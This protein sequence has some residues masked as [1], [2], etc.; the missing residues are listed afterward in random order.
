M[1]NF[2]SRRCNDEAGY[3][4]KRWFGSKP[5]IQLPPDEPFAPLIEDVAPWVNGHKVFVMDE[6]GEGA[7][8]ERHSLS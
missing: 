3:R 6:D 5:A 2:H 8:V 7:F 1:G 4:G